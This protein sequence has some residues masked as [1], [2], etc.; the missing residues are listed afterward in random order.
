M[1]E[2]ER[3]YQALEDYNRVL[4]LLDDDDSAAVVCEL[5]ADAE[6]KLRALNR[7]LH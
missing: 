7:Y 3:L 2:R 6:E 4:E 5:I 1:T